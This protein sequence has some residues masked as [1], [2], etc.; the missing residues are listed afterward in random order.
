MTEVSP[1]PAPPQE[2]LP[3]DSSMKRWIITVDLDELLDHSFE[4]FLD[5]IAERAG[6][7]LLTDITYRAISVLADGSLSLEV[8]GDSTLDRQSR[9]CNS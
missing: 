5:L 8:Q 9:E 1:G 2:P 6:V 4:G 7:P 3:K